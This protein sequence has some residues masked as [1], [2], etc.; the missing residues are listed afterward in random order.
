MKTKNKNESKNENENRNKNKNK[1]YYI[2]EYDDIYNTK[3]NKIQLM[4][5]TLKN[6]WF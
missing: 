4:V 2:N 6:T 1:N 3:F 5:D